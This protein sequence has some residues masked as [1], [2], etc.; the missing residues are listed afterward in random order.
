V[1]QAFFADGDVGNL[2]NV[3][4]IAVLKSSKQQDAAVQLVRFLLSPAAQQYF[5]TVVN[6]YAV[7]PNVISNPD[8]TDTK[9]VLQAAPKI[10]L[11]QLADLKGTLDLL[12]QAG[13][14]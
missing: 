12:R 14:L 11:D 7:T 5:T 1:A 3:A 8:L 10:N 4:G 13:L 2:V 9:V 6:E